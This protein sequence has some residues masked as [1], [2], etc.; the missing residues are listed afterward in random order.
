MASEYSLISIY[1]LVSTLP[2]TISWPKAP[3]D[4]YTLIWSK[5]CCEHQLRLNGLL[6]CFGDG[7]RLFFIIIIIISLPICTPNVDITLVSS[8]LQRS[9]HRCEYSS[10]F[11]YKVVHASGG[12]PQNCFG[13][14]VSSRPLTCLV[15]CCLILGLFAGSKDVNHFY[16]FISILYLLLLLCIESSCFIE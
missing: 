1:Y 3:I 6:L 8:N 16:I 11:T 14:W 12:I 10:C 7:W 9:L 4:S 5:S 15:I 13:Q 2:C